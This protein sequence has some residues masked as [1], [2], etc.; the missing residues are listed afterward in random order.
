[1]R[2]T[3][4]AP[5]L[6]AML[7]MVLLLTACGKTNAHNNTAG[8]TVSTALFDFSITDVS[9]VESYPGVVNHEGMS[10][11][12]EQAM[13]KLVGRDN[14]LIQREPNMGTEDFGAFMNQLTIP[15][16]YCDFGFGD[17]QRECRFPAHGCHY[18]ANE[19]G[20]AYAAAL[21]VQVCLDFFEAGDTL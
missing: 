3:L 20:L 21:F 2:R 12:A 7:G 5:G 4:A 10:A 13:V 11:L 18:R 9:L 6:A 17:G 15:G 19:E 1:M 16:C 14:V 8:E